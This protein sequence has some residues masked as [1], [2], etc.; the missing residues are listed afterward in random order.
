MR[1]RNR[2][3]HRT[4]RVRAHHRQSILSGFN[5]KRGDGGMARV[6]CHRCQGV[7]DLPDTLHYPDGRTVPADEYAREQKLRH[8]DCYGEKKVNV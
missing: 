5:E 1:C 7:L 8:D 4:M 2:R 3:A 6:R